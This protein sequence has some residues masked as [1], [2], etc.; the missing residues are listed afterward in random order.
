MANMIP[1]DLP[2]LFAAVAAF[3]VA[4]YVLSDGFDLGVGILFLAAP[5]DADRDVMMA[6]IEPVWDGNETWLVMG[7]TLLFAA[8]PAAYYVLLPAFYLPIMFMLFALIF[9]GIAFGFR[10]Q[11]VSYRWV[12]DIAFA[13]GSVLAVLCQGFVL[14]GFI[15]GVPM[16]AGMFSG[17]PFD[18][19]TILG[20]LCGLGLLGGYALL[21]AGWLIWKTEGSTQIFAREV[22]HRGTPCSRRDDGDRQ[23]LDRAGRPQCRKPMVCLAQHRLSRALAFVGRHC[24]LVHL[25]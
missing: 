2:L 1:F 5:R 11:A 3:S 7:G 13:G 16:E 20:L 14:G 6:S 23:R 21:G 12:W 4:V 8:F 17:G 25:A 19:F 22:G 9:R 10:L 15:S 24:R 18:C